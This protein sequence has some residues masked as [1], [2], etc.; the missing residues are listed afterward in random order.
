M[1]GVL[2]FHSLEEALR[3]GALQT[4]DGRLT[5]DTHVAAN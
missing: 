3:A 4:A 5:V 2:V 1:V